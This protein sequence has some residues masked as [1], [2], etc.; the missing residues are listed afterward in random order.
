MER[1]RAEQRKHKNKLII[2][3]S[4]ILGI[5]IGLCIVFFI[6]G[7][8]GNDTIS[9]IGIPL[10]L[11]Q[12]LSFFLSVIIAIYL[13]IIIH[14]SG[15]LVL[16]LLSGYRFISFRIFSFIIIHR[17]DGFH[18][19]KFSIPGTGGQCLMIPPDTSDGKIPYKLYNAGGVLFNFI[20][21]SIAFVCLLLFDLN[22]MLSSF[23]IVFS[24]LGIILG[25][26]NGIPMKLSGI[27]NDGYN[28]RQLG[29]DHISLRAFYLQLKINGMLTEGIRLKD[30][31][32]QWFNIPE[33]IDMKNN[34]H[35]SLFLLR[36]G[37]YMDQLKFEEAND[38]LLGISSYSQYLIGLYQNER[39]CELIFLEMVL[40]PDKARELNIF[41]K[42]ISTYIKQT[43]RYM[44]GKKRLLYATALVIENDKVLA[45]KIY[46]EAQR[47][48]NSY[49]LLGEA[50]SELELIE[51][52]KQK[53]A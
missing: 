20:F 35:L 15:H 5:I 26:M 3:L 38:L 24:I 4:L 34:M 2:L 25:L 16:G 41:T 49:P 52:V 28:I 17:S 6:N 43:N 36:G 53:F 9:D 40:H 19:K 13:Q 22:M 10:L 51:Y 31:P 11:F 50:E 1:K 47:M 14:E 42:E 12:L 46:E 48:K 18:L 29:K 44:I 39:L 30:M 32:T 7:R 27:G 8:N 21:S 33:D 45:D 37:W 23:L